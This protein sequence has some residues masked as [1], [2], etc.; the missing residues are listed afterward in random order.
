MLLNS[1]PT[2]ENTGFIADELSLILS[3]VLYRPIS[4]YEF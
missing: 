4:V 2:L 3:L 1:L